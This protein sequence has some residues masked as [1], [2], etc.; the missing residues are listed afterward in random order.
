MKR[1][2]GDEDTTLSQPSLP[3]ELWDYIGQFVL[4]AYDSRC[5][6]YHTVEEQDMALQCASRYAQ[7]CR[8][9]Q[10]VVKPRLDEWRAV[11]C[12]RVC[13]TRRG[14]IHCNC[15][16]NPE[17]CFRDV[18]DMSAPNTLCLTCVPTYCK[19]CHHGS[20]GCMALQECAYCMRLFCEYCRDN[21][22][23]WHGRGCYGLCAVCYARWEH[24]LTPTESSDDEASE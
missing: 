9:V 12:C 7:T 14:K 5:V 13:K 24:D 10:G 4:R 20:C 1:K 19:G 21:P 23:C 6:V 2:C 18:A 8:E 3:R 22:D 17:C 15:R 11:E 16:M